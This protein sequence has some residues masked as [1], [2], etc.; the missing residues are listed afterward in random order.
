MERAIT[1]RNVGEGPTQI[2]GGVYIVCLISAGYQLELCVAIT[3]NQECH[4][5]PK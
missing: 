4:V 3:F 5:L 1:L 2:D